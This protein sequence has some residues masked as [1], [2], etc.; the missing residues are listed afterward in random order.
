MLTDLIGWFTLNEKSKYDCVCLFLCCTK[1]S[2]VK[3]YLHHTKYVMQMV[4]ISENCRQQ[5][6]VSASIK[7]RVV[8]TVALSTRE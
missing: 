6:L 7:A 8:D 4:A 2:V 3:I 5:N 1:G